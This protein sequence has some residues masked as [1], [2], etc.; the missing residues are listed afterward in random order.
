MHVID[1]DS[2]FVLHH[3][4]HVNK[5]FVTSLMHHPYKADRKKGEEEKNKKGKSWGGFM[6]Y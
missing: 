1:N 4:W 6:A 3:M 5:T 2:F